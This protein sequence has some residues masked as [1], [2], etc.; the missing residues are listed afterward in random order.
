MI[1]W[2]DG[3]N[4]RSKLVK[5]YPRDHPRLEVHRYPGY[6]PELYPVGGCGHT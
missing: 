6:C 1:L 5:A 4:Y 3:P 2:D